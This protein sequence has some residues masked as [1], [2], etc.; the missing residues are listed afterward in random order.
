[1]TSDDDLAVT[2]KLAMQAAPFLDQNLGHWQ[3]LALAI[4]VARCHSVQVRPVHGGVGPSLS[5]S[6]E[7]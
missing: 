4:T 5:A 2:N 7:D 1:M 6:E 3:S